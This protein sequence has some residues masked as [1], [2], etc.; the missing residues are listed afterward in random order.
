VWYIVCD[1]S[2]HL[3][4]KEKGLYV[5]GKYIIDGA[6]ADKT[7]SQMRRFLFGNLSTNNVRCVYTPVNERTLRCVDVDGL[8]TVMGTPVLV[9]GHG[10]SNL[11]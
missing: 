11:I 7:I 6:L 10:S 3:G 4:E 2:F 5:R 1:R 8:D 9:P